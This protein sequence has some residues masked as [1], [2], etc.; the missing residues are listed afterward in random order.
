MYIHCDGD[1]FGA[2]QYLKK[3]LEHRTSPHRG[4]NASFADDFIKANDRVQLTK[5]HKFHTDRAY[6]YTISTTGDYRFGPF[7]ILVKAEMVTG[8]IPSW[9]F[10]GTLQEFIDQE[11]ANET[12]RVLAADANRREA[13]QAQRK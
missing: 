2:S 4:T 13:L 3:A 6:Q 5:S 7:E 10:R 9:C 12:K 1:P 8:D 11:Q